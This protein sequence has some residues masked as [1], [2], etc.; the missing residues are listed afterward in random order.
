MVSF[1]GPPTGCQ[2]NSWPTPGGWHRRVTEDTYAYF[3]EQSL[4]NFDLNMAFYQRL[5]R[6]RFAQT[7]EELH[8][9]YPRLRPVDDLNAFKGVEGLYVLI[10]DD[11]CQIYVGQSQ[12]ITAR[13]RQH[14][15]RS[16]D[17]DRLVF[18]EVHNSRLSVDAFRALD[19][20]RVLVWAYPDPNMYEG[21]I[22]ATIPDEFVA[23]R[24]A[25]GLAMSQ[26]DPILSSGTGRRL[27]D[28]TSSAP[29][30]G[31]TA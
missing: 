27:I 10:L 11:Y 2:P 24:I 9:A 20:T 12:D 28:H 1:P 23:N 3:A 17:I 21:K 16:K 31:I 30:A 15:T 7:V 13:I 25:G 8:R 18:G 22:I 29:S 19:T 26:Y 14:W 6:Q 5:D 4:Q